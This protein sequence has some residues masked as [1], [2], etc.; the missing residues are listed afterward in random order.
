MLGYFGFQ[1]SLVLQPVQMMQIAASAND[2]DLDP[3]VAGARWLS[4]FLSL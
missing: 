3:G 2:A 1:G 4:N